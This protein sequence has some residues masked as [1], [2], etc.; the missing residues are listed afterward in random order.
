VLWHE[1]CA[2]GLVLVHVI[3]YLA[4]AR[5][6]REPLISRYRAYHENSRSRRSTAP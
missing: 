3:I 1:L 4:S 6:A 5:V 2:I